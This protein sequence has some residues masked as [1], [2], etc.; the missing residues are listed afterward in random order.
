[1]VRVGVELI[2]LVTAKAGETAVICVVLVACAAT[3]PQT[4]VPPGIDSEIELVMIERRGNPGR[5]RMA[6]ET[7]VV[8]IRHNMV[9]IG[10]EL[11]I[12]LMAL[13]TIRVL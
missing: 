13:V 2:V 10:R 8:E 4:L 1:M 12:G 9:G 7:I 5:R 3:C 11:V 6:R